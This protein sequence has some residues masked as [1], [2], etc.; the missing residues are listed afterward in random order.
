MDKSNPRFELDRSTLTGYMV[1]DCPS[2]G[3]NRRQAAGL[4]PGTA[5]KCQCG[6]TTVAVSGD[7]LDSLQRV[8]DELKR[9]IESMRQTLK[10]ILKVTVKVE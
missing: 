10:Q 2:C 1:Y 7:G 4:H 9:S 5:V 6:R 3:E 8:L